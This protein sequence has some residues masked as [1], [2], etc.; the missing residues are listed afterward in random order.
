MRAKRPRLSSLDTNLSTPTTVTVPMPTLQDIEATPQLNATTSLVSP[1]T[2]H[3]DL[4]P[5][6]PHSGNDGTTVTPVVALE[7]GPAAV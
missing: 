7:K 3:V 4:E 5:T 6:P 1:D 2:P